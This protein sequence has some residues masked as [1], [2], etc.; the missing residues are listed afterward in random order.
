M[1][2]P[3][4][5]LTVRVLLLLPIAAALAMAAI[6]RLTARS[7]YWFVGP[8][9]L[10]VV[11]ARDRRPLVARVTVTYFGPLAG[12]RPSGGSW[13]TDG[14]TYGEYRW[15][16]PERSYPGMVGIVGHRP[17]TL[18]LRRSDRSFIDGARFHVEAEG[19]QSFT[20]TPVDAAGRPLEF[21]TWDPPVFRVGL[22][23]AGAAGVSAFWTTRP[24]LK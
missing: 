15:M 23:P 16:A 20:F 10:D 11:D 24:E 14:A 2:L 1:R 6:D 4:V 21:D 9:E 3:R 17:R 19:Y 8:Y 22:R 5:R 13:V 18:F 12:Q 7:P